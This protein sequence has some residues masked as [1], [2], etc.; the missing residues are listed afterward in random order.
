MRP[1]TM[2]F[3]GDAVGR[4]KPPRQPGSDCPPRLCLLISGKEGEGIF[5]AGVEMVMMRPKLFGSICFRRRLHAEKR[6]ARVDGEDPVPTF[7]RKL[8]QPVHEA[9]LPRN[10]P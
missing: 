8:I 1:G 9:E 10:S 4:P 3:D 5:A 6:A 7:G 2:V